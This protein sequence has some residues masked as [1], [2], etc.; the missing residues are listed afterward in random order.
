MNKAIVKKVEKDS[1]AALV[2]ITEGDILLSIN[3][4]SLIDI[5]DYMMLIQDEQLLLTIQ[6]PSGEIWEIEI[7][8]DEDEDLGIT[9]TEEL[10]DGEKSCN[11]KCIFCFIDQLPKGMRETL[12]FKDDDSRLSFL[13][14]NYVTLTN[15]P[16]E[17]LER[18]ANLR[19][20]PINISVHTTNPE[21]RK[22]M[23]NNRFAGDIM[24]KINYLA[25]RGITMNTQIVLCKGV[26]D[27]NELD[28]TINDLSK[29]YPHIESLSVVPVGLSKHRKGLYKLE[30]FT[31]E[32]AN[33]TI[34]QIVIH[35]KKMHKK[36]TINFV[37]IA[38][39]F[40]LTADKQIPDSNHYDGFSQ[41]ENGVGLLASMRDEIIDN[42]TNTTYQENE[43]DITI[44]TGVLAYPFIVEMCKKITEK[45]G[46]IKINIIKVDNKFFG[47]KVTVVG[48]LTGSDLL[49]E[50]EN[51]DI[52][53]ELLIARSMLKA[54]R[55]I[56]LDNV[57]VK[58]IEQKFNTTI[59]P[60]LNEGHDFIKKIVKGV[61]NG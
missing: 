14:G 21:L 2:N 45:Y 52:S 11:N 31:K 51:H 43:R 12:Y 16:M 8:K 57:T 60:V 35:Q 20:S 5:F 40:Y 36:N 49:R 54:D 19:L 33:K 3:S 39:E 13:T 47:Y 34:E 7:D 29:L 18:I 50:L 58:D 48:L 56:F 55:D 61:A 32:E 27:G 38:D 23:L 6:K 1:I 9:F 44:A 59:I 42:L 22:A 17:E 4:N 46:K 25:N 30:P 10:I 28:R 26:N 37:Y 41:I 15:M 53:Q 24:E